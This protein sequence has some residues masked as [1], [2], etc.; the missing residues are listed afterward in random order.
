[1][2]YG[3]LQSLF[4][5][6]KPGEMNYKHNVDVSWIISLSSLSGNWGMVPIPQEESGGGRVCDTVCGGSEKT[7]SAYL[8]DAVRDKFVC[9]LKCETAQKHLLTKE[10][11]TFQKAV[12]YTVS[13]KTVVWDSS[14]K[15][16]AVFSRETCA[17]CRRCGKT[18]HAEDYC[19]YKDR[20]CHQ[21]GWRGHI[22]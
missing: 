4:A 14:F 16:N 19:W 6:A 11:Q 22:G 8:E 5:P 9:G 10:T 7:Y 21:C 3:L 20:Y 18:N 15:V 1:M 17:K 12:N 13:V 2:T